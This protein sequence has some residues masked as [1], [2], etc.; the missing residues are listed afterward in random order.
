LSKVL[1]V[2]KTYPNP[3]ATHDETV[4]TAAVTESGEWLRIYPV[5]YRYLPADKQYKKWQ[6]IEIGL[7]TRG[8]QNDPRPESREPDVRSM[9][10]LGEPLSS[11]NAWQ[12]RR[13][14]IDRMRHST[15]SQLKQQWELD[16]TSLGIIRPVEILDLEATRTDD[17]WAPKHEAM[18]TQPL[19][20]GERKKLQ[21]IPYSFRYV[22]RCEDEDEPHRLLLEDWELGALFLKERDSKGED[23]AV[24]SVRRKFLGELCGADRDTRFFVGTRHP[25]NQWLVI[26]VFYPPKRPQE[27]PPLFR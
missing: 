21:K 4:C 24:E 7:A 6:W 2:V 3:S 17:K 12:A 22:F 16:R 1:V 8:Y 18:M 10:L 27:T 25:V 20:I 11:K 19:L 5:P 14:L 13:S 15:L 23:A 9:R 26:G